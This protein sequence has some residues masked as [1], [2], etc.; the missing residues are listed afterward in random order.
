MAEAV[1]STAETT[2]STTRCELLDS[3]RLQWSVVECLMEC[4]VGK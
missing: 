3:W 2:V 1:P 4:V